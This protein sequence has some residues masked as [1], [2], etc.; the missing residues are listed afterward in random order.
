MGWQSNCVYGYYVSMVTFMSCLSTTLVLYMVITCLSTLPF[1][2]AVDMFAPS[3]HKYAVPEV[4]QSTPHWAKSSPVIKG[5]FNFVHMTK[6]FLKLCS[7]MFVVKW[8]MP[9]GPKIVPLAVF[10]LSA[11]L[12]T[13]T[14]SEIFMKS[15]YKIQNH[16][17]PVLNTAMIGSKS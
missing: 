1:F 14:L 6:L 15:W 10:T 7:A 11:F 5:C 16:V 2:I 8:T 17:A 13:S 9:I 12:M 3:S 4:S